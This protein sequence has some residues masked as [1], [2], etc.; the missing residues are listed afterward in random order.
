[1]SI[2]KEAYLLCK[3]IQ[4]LSFREEIRN[5]INDLNK[6][7]DKTIGTEK[8]RSRFGSYAKRQMA[9]FMGYLIVD[10]K[11]GIIENSNMLKVP[12]ISDNE[13]ELLKK[14][15]FLI[16]YICKICVSRVIEFIPNLAEILDPYIRF[17]Y[18]SYDI[19]IEEIIDI[20]YLQPLKVAFNENILIKN[21]YNTP[22]EL[23]RKID[24]K[25][26]LGA[27]LGFT[28]KI[29]DCDVNES[30]RE[31][32]DLV[33]K[34]IVGSNE[35][36]L[37]KLLFSIMCIRE[38]LLVIAQMIYQAI[39][40]EKLFVLDNN[41]VFNIS[42][43]NAHLIGNGITLLSQPRGNEIFCNP[44]DLILLKIELNNYKIDTLCL[45]QKIVLTIKKDFGET[46]EFSLRVL[47]DDLNPFNNLLKSLKK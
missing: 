44:R 27:V 9:Q 38:I 10:K 39:L 7:T 6:C 23:S 4:K 19:D 3:E 14:S 24:S 8:D 17:S 30:P 28:K 43:Q 15:N 2:K 18:P 26:Y 45:I 31:F 37:S 22:I 35:Y 21:I 41:N 25:K 32:D 34:N 12:V 13:R 11:R 29:Y 1:M 42:E 36:I 20:K 16:N 47:D 46:Q 40:N 5:L 33:F